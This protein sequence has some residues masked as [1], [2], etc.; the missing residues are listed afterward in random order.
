MK[1]HIT[2]IL[3][4]LP[5]IRGLRKDID[6]YEKWGLPGHF[7]NPIPS[8]TEV[9]QYES[10]IFK[11]LNNSDELKGIDLRYKEQMTL[12]T[13]MVPFYN[14]MPF[15]F[16]KKEDTRYYFNNPNY[17]YSD[18]IFLY[19]I[20]RNYRPKRFIEI[21][22]GFSS[23]ATLDTNELFFDNNIHCSFI[24]P[25]P[26]LLLK[27][28]NI[29]DKNIE[30]ISKK[31]QEVDLTL[32]DT[33][34]ENDILFIDSSHVLKTGSDLH[35]ILFEILPRLNKRVLI[36]FHDIFY[37]FEYPKEWVFDF[38]RAWNEIYAVRAFLMHNH[39]YNIVLFNHYLLSEN[40]KWFTENMP[41][42]TKNPGGS[43]WL[44]KQN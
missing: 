2:K 8:L 31:I 21:G 4:K 30:L 7:Y 43:I 18:A 11:I 29:K 23:C 24:E 20:I 15:P 16:D 37:P 13:S 39:D 33:L 12:L 42:C 40:L 34:Q 25:Y 36:H 17:S 9:K 38:N 6:S 26:E 10:K 1:K 28:I 35:T 19:L 14:E 41:L 3:D 32:F 44:Q 22:S 27:L 5:Y